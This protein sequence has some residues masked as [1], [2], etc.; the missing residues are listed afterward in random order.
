MGKNRDIKAIANSLAITILHELLFL[1]T[2]RPETKNH[3]ENE[4]IEYRGQSIKKIENIKVSEKDKEIIKK[5][6]IDKINNKLNKKYSDIK[7]SQ[8]E[9]L[10]KV[11]E[12]LFYIFD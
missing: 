4:F 3:L 8:K 9:I 7:I 6:I 5:K 11:D 12:S 2:N 1:H 10:E